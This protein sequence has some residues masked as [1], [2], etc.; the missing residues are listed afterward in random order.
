MSAARLAG[1]L[2]A[3]LMIGAQPAMA[4]AWDDCQVKDNPDLAIEGCTTTLA[5]ASGDQMLE[6]EYHRAFAYFGKHDFYHAV[7]DFTSVI[8]S[9][10]IAEVYAYRG[11]AYVYQ[12][13]DDPAFADQAISDLNQALALKPD[14]DTN[15][16]KDFSFAYSVR[17]ATNLENGQDTQA[18]S[19]EDSAVKMNPDKAAA[20]NTDFGS[21]YARRALKSLANGEYDHAVSDLQQANQLDPAST[22]RLAPYLSEAQSGK[23]GPYAAI[24][25]GE[26]HEKDDAYDQA[27]ND[28]TDAIIASPDMAQAYLER[29]EAFEVLERYSDARSD[30]DQAVKLDS[31]NW[32]AYYARGYFH[33]QMAEF[34]LADADFTQASAVIDQG[35]DTNAEGEKAI[36]DK[37]SKSLQFDKKLEDHW[38]SYLKDI[39]TSNNYANW[40]SAPYDLYAGRHNLPKL[41]P[42]ATA[43]V[44][45]MAIP[46]PGR[47]WSWWAI[48]LVLLIVLGVGGGGYQF[49]RQ[50]NK[51]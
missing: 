23:P 18:I 13:D 45:P 24:A 22:D 41:P 12:V 3:C 20:F 49:Y 1:A 39:Q 5:S 48:P 34:D 16:E 28:Y 33:Q 40:S 51:A 17:A 26:Q 35:H 10:S 14:L 36:I 32:R 30:F 47:A 4:D 6:A 50:R 11:L 7:K 37:A 43:S 9:R 38:V 42:P 21:A 27:V 29:A 15:L 25:R 46:E 2:I 44:A 31:G 8:G 19:D